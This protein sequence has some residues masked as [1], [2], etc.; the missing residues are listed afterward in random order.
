MKIKDIFLKTY[1]EAK[2]KIILK[3]IQKKLKKAKKSELIMLKKVTRLW[4]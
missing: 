4:Q 1:R 3:S 2:D